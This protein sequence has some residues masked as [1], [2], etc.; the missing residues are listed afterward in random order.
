MNTFYVYAY[1][2]KNGEPYYIG[3]G[4]DNR[5]YIQHR[6]KGKGVHTP[7]DRSRIVFP[8]QTL[9]EIG[10]FAL[11]RRLIRW[12]GRKDLR[13][14][15][16]HNRTDGGDGTTGY[17]R[18]EELKEAQRV[19]VTEANKVRLE[20]KTHHFLIDHPMKKPEMRKKNSERNSGKGNSSYGNYHAA[21]HLN[22]GT[23]FIC[24]FC[25]ASSSLGNHKR[26]HGNNC[27]LNKGEVE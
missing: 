2:R 17:V 24:E 4:Y 15:I 5:A 14:G 9:T 6:Y 7:K 1:L 8:E 11:E 13:A 12:Y 21:D 18:S 23:K 20:N 27:R 19:W 10:A 22:D 26:W 16:L 3:K 25:N